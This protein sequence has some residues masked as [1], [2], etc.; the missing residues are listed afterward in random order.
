MTML[1]KDELPFAVVG[2]RCLI[3][4]EA[5]KTRTAGGIEIPATSQLRPF[6]GIL[7]GAG[8]QA[9]DKLHDHGIKIGD[10]VLYGKFAG[11]IEEWDRIIEGRADLD[12]DDEE[13]SRMPTQPGRPERYKHPSGAIREVAPVVV[14]NVDDLLASVELAARFRAGHI[15]VQF[16][17]T[18]DGRTQHVISERSVANGH[19]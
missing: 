10:R 11:V 9:L 4:A 13:W 16:A 3:L 17:T 1:S 14:L 5:P 2:E 15:G 6:M 12:P 8:L 18:A 19:A 7:M